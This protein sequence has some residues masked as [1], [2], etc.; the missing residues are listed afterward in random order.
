MVYRE[1]ELPNKMDYND[2]AKAFRCY[3]YSVPTLALSSGLAEIE[4]DE[5]F[6]LQYFITGSQAV[7]FITG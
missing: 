4:S 5:A 1:M 7:D 6:L 3:F 2:A